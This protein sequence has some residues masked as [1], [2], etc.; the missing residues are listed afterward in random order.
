MCVCVYFCGSTACEVAHLS[1]CAWCCSVRLKLNT[2]WSKRSVRRR[3]CG[4]MS[5]RTNWVSFKY[6]DTHSVTVS[7]YRARNWKYPH[8]FLHLNVPLLPQELRT[9]RQNIIKQ[10]VLGVNKFKSSWPQVVFSCLSSS[11]SQCRFWSRCSWLHLVF[12]FLQDVVLLWWRPGG[13]SWGFLHSNR[14]IL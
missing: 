8:F 1:C 10:Q 12:V 7:I 5:P 11:Q 13:W 4:R 2:C 3:T 14:I 9:N 6:S